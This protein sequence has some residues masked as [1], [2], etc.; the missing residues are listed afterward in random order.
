MFKLHTPDQMTGAWSVF[1]DPRGDQH[2]LCVCKQTF[3]INESGAPLRE[4][5][6]EPIVEAPV[7]TD[8]ENPVCLAQETELSAPSGGSDL[9]VEA[10]LFNPHQ[11]NPCPVGIQLGPQS[12]WLRVWGK[13]VW[14]K[15]FMGWKQSKPEPLNTLPIQF[16][17]TF[18]G[19]DATTGRVCMANPAGT[20]FF[21]KSPQEGLALP[22]IER[23]ETRWDNPRQPPHPGG[24][25][26]IASHWSDRAQ[27]AGTYDAEWQ[28]KQFPRLPLD[29][30]NRFYHVA[31]PDLRFEQPLGGRETLQIKNLSPWEDF[32]IQLP[33]IP[34]EAT[35]QIGG[36]RQKKALDLDRV[37]LQATRQRLSL[38]YKTSFPINRRLHQIR[39]LEVTHA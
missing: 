20:G 5:N 30:S 24:M 22:Q 16:L 18:G 9:V 14:Q 29:F 13:R 36:V 1:E 12:L 35:L 6:P 33:Q 37:F 31:T 32:Q 26:F 39:G 3:E 34:L 15:T 38:T 19:T 8:P 23:W 28:A 17:H 27:F 21:D 7:Y 11:Q 4:I 10:D 25:G 2:L